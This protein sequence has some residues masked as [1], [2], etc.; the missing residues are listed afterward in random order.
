MDRGR[1]RGY[2]DEQAQRTMYPPRRQRV[3]PPASGGRFS[4]YPPYSNHRQTTTP[5]Q[6][7]KGYPNES[8]RQSVRRE[9]KAATINNQRIKDND[10]LANR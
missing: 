3:L 8:A 7:Q 9:S 10:H 5:I 1:E 4:T 6:R 2:E